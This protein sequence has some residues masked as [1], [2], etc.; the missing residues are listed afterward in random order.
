MKDW[1]EY[2]QSYRP[3]AAL[4]VK[5]TAKKSS[6]AC[7]WCVTNRIYWNRKIFIRII[8]RFNQHLRLSR[9]YISLSNQINYL[10]TLIPINYIDTEFMNEINEELNVL[11]E[12]RK[13]VYN[14]I[15]RLWRKS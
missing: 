14:L 13:R 15:F 3:G 9:I 12:K 6:W 10:T 5:G 2:N 7:P 11:N 8:M 1:L 4:F